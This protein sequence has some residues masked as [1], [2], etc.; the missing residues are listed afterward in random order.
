MSIAYSKKV[1]KI[2]R[3]L[4]ALDCEPLFK[5]LNVFKLLNIKF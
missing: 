4:S 2:G 5:E 3:M 1:K